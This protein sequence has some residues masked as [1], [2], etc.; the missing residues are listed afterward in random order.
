M[1]ATSDVSVVDDGPMVRA[2]LR[3]L[4]CSPPIALT[5]FT[6][7]AATWSSAGPGRILLMIASGQRG[8]DDCHLNEV[9]RRGSS[10]TAAAIS[11]PG[12]GVIG[13]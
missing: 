4:D 12:E 7:P 3:A 10:R 9:E 5:A 6:D 2:V 13:Y 11:R 8:S 1:D